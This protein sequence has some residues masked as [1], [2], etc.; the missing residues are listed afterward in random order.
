[1][2][3]LKHY[4]SNIHS[5]RVKKETEYTDQRSKASSLSSIGCLRSSIN[6][7]KKM[8]EMDIYQLE[9]KAT[10]QRSRTKMNKLTGSNK[11]NVSSSKHYSEYSVY[12]G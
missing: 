5:N 4:M 10:A 12:S 7:K 2:D 1:M 3:P 6:I 9:K 8:K 11:L